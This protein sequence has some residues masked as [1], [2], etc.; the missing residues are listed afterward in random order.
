MD[1]LHKINPFTRPSS[2]QAASSRE[3]QSLESHARPSSSL[4]SNLPSLPESDGEVDSL[5]L[6]RRYLTP[7]PHTPKR[8][9]R[10]PSLLRSLAHHPSLS[11]LRSKKSEKKK[12]GKKGF[13]ELADQPE[14]VRYDGLRGLKGSKSVP[15][16]LRDGDGKSLL[17]SRREVMANDQ[18]SI[19][20]SPL[21]LPCRP[22][23]IS[24]NINA[25]DREKVVTST[26][27][28][29]ITINTLPSLPAD[30]PWTGL[31]LR[32]PLLL[33]NITT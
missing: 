9:A 8:H 20:T 1:I 17:N 21:F 10:T 32:L 18:I 16:D 5:E 7:G 12:K 19:K 22:L 31:T 4:E 13:E 6:Q 29:E 33:F 27:Q 23:L 11:A 25:N 26:T 30:P 24:P 3:R 15:R 14:S 2:R 28:L